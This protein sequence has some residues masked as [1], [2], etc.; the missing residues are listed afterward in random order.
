VLRRKALG[1]EALAA[2]R[3]AVLGGRYPALKE[4]LRELI[5]LREQIVRREL[6]GPGSEIREIHEQ[7]LATWR[8]R[9]DRL[10][11]DLARQIPEMGLGTRLEGVDCEAVASAL[12][13]GSALVEFIRFSPCDFGPDPGIQGRAA[14]EAFRHRVDRN[15]KEIPAT[16]HRAFPLGPLASDRR[17][18]PGR[19][20]S[21]RK[22]W[23]T[24]GPTGDAARWH[25]PRYLAFI[26]MSGQ[27]DRVQMIDLGEAK[28]IDGL[29][30]DFRESIGG[31]FRSWGYRDVV[32]MQSAPDVPQRIDAGRALRAAVFDPL[33]PTLDGRKRL[34]M[35]PD[36]D[37]SWLPFE[38]LAT[39]DGRRLIE[40][41]R[42]SYLSAG[43]D[44]LRNGIDTP[45]RSSA[46]L[47]V[48]DPDFDLI[49][50][51]RRRGGF[52]SHLPGKA[53]PCPISE[54]RGAC[55]FQ[56]ADPA[57]AR[58]SRDLDR[59]VLHFTRLPGT[60]LEGEAI[61]RLLGVAPW[62]GSLALEG[63]L[64]SRC[65]S[66]RIVHLATHGFYLED[67]GDCLD[68]WRDDFGVTD[69]LVISP[70]RLLG[71]SPE[72]PLLR[73]GLALA[74]ANT[75]L[76][77]R[78]LPVEAEDGLL[79]AEDVSGLD[80]LATELVVLSACET[81]LG[82]VHVGEGVFGLR[83]AFMLAGAK[84]LVM[85]LWKVPDEPT[86]ELME[87]FYGRLLAG[88]GRAEALRQAQL[89]MKEKY[90]DPFYWG[91]FICQG[92]PSRLG[93]VESQTERAVDSA[94]LPF[95]A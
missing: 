24:E 52:W 5:T 39:D 73:S 83:R 65:R 35:A 69:G 78:A 87:D 61:A 11:A 9:R 88:E 30:A 29:I 26:L 66:P 40:E 21:G 89:A 81:G 71:R 15:R 1:A 70:N 18:R 93:R 3:D 20:K 10:E 74:G 7:F 59:G 42:F 95:S 84:T 85:S 56:R 31:D 19:S 27:H 13:E 57:D 75:W 38:V 79:T 77:R 76:R 82:Q 37:L 47:V 92:D 33:A 90:P 8:A 41:Y 34:L 62:L 16:R 91:A 67:Q 4:K 14:A 45:A 68:R 72:N 43:R 86:R 63:R 2:Q 53:R 54:R 48:A 46:A 94:G 49:G 55:Q 22:S 58:H 6:A 17:I 44:I 32:K 80:L 51:N 36:G 50:V 25:P 64:K 23:R 12:P 28:V 60:R